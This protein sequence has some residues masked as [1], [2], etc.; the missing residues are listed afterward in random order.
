MDHA[1][2]LAILNRISHPSTTGDDLIQ[3]VEGLRRVLKG[4]SVS[5]VLNTRSKRSVRKYRSYTA[6]QEEIEGLR[7]ALKKLKSEKAKSERHQQKQIEK[8]VIQLE[9]LTGEDRLVARESYT[10]AEVMQAMVDRF[11]KHHGIP[12]ALAERNARLRAEG[13]DIGKITSAGFQQW[14]KL[15]CYPAYVIEQ[16]SEMTSD[17]LLPR[18]G[19]S[20]EERVF[21]VELYRQKETLSNRELAELCTKQFGRLVTECSIKGELNRLRQKGK[22]SMYRP[23]LAAPA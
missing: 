15:D 1:R 8:L 7:Q 21:L 23:R 19:W 12:A 14:R 13:Q 5:D 2:V 20:D 6:S 4:E 16:I 18:G 22:V 11:G 3:T 9:K 17:D 10:Y